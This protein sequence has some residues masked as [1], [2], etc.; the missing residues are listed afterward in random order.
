MKL[1]WEREANHWLPERRVAVLGG[2]TDSVW[3]EE[4]AEAEIVVL[5]Y[6]ILDWHADKL[7]ELQPKA[8]ILDESHYVKNAR[9]ARTKAALELAA[10]LPDGALRL[11]LTGTPVLNRAEELVSQ[12]RVLGRL[13]DF[14]SGARLTRQAATTASTGTCARTATCGARRSR[15]C[16][17]CPRSATTPSRSCCRTSTSTAW[18]SAT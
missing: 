10:Q 2:R 15:C 17:S 11:A 14:G 12:L 6:D 13:K 16:R 8:L 9:A 1:V 18:R 3:T 5:N 4:T 7:V